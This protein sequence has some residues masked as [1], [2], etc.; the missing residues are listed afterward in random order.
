M[1]FYFYILYLM[2]I[3]I[4]F[5][6]S[7]NFEKLN[8]S[9]QFPEVLNMAPYMSGT[10]D[11]SPLYSLYAV[12]VHLDIM[13]AAYSGHYVCYVKNIQGEWFRTDDSRVTFFILIYLFSVW[14]LLHPPLP[15]FQKKLCKWCYH[16]IFWL[17]FS[18]VLTFSWQ[19]RYSC[20][21]INIWRINFKRR[22]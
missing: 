16:L 1:L 6:Q 9:V 8:K 17:W 20:L 21:I 22:D 14:C 11:K 5:W 4:L 2:R 7:G 19:E 3:L 15:T 10:K 12:V 13:N 18:Y